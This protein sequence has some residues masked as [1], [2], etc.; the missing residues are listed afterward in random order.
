MQK[1]ILYLLL[2]L[3]TITIVNCSTDFDLYADYEDTSIV[4]C[5]ADISDD[6][7][8]VRITKAYRGTDNILLNAK[9]PDSS[10]YSYKLNA[11]LTGLKNGVSLEPI[12][13]DTITIH[14]KELSD[15]IINYY[16]DTVFLNP[17]YA[18]D[19][20]MYYAVGKLDKDALYTLSISK[21]NG[22]NV[23]ASTTL[24][25]E[26]YV[27]KPDRRII[28]TQNTSGSIEWLSAKNGARYYISTV[29]NYSEYESGYNDTLQKSVDWFHK[30][31]NAKSNNGG[32]TMEIVYSGAD[33]YSNLE[34]QLPDIPNVKRWAENVEIKIVCGSQVL[35][36]Y[37]AI[38]STGA[39]INEEVPTYTNI[40]NGV[41]I[42]A[43][44]HTIIEKIK[45]SLTS[46]RILVESYDLGFKY[47]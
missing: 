3:V 10:N 2:L 15:T 38:N 7:T 9:N 6:T 23:S 5:I 11:S 46:E 27:T 20:L 16:G 33:F 12:P 22:R 36:S 26:F 4:Y 1:P 14:H 19:Q 8:W 32:E 28:F 43:S 18:P 40:N 25:D 17:F 31:V 39:S 45:L 35:I 37:I 34:A 30:T 29:F 47:K 41:G 21:N 24:V 13:L 42:F 44:R